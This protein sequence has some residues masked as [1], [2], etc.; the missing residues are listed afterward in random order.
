MQ[1]HATYDD[2]VAEVRDHLVGLAE[3]AIAAGVPQVWVDPGI[4]FD[5]TAAHNLAL[6]AHLDELVGTGFP[7]LV[8]TS[9]K[10]FLGG[11]PGRSV[12]VGEPAHVDDRAEGLLAT[13]T[14][15]RAAR[16]WSVLVHERRATTTTAHPPA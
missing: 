11:L 15:A 4:G 2:V 16:G 14:L 12:G 7:V 13:A 1:Q 10:G 5:K 9:R 3:A 8:G 6:L